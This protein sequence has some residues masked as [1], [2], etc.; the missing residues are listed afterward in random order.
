MNNNKINK[1]ISKKNF[2]GKL[3]LCNNLRNLASL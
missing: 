2:I 3:G 1:A